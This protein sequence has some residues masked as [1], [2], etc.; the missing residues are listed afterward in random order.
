M[1]EVKS[2]GAAIV[3]SLVWTGLGQLYAGRIGRGIVLMV[4]T[5]FVWSLGFMSGCAGT[6]WSAGEREQRH[7]SGGRRGVGRTGGGHG[8]VRRDGSDGPSRRRDPARLVGVGHVRRQ[9][10]LR[11]VQPGCG[12]DCVTFAFRIP[13]SRTGRAGAPRTTGGRK[14]MFVRI[15]HHPWSVVLLIQSG[16]SPR[17]P[18]GALHR[19]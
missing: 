10:A 12:R 1:Q 19:R 3:L 16:S 8:S 13:S 14:R 11:G 5:P 6:L 17:L 15:R 9:E 4:A 18:R 7:A 2:S